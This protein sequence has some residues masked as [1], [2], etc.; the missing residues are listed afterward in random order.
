MCADYAHAKLKGK[1]SKQM[2]V[3]ARRTIFLYTYCCSV[4]QGGQAPAA[5]RPS[6]TGAVGSI[7]ISVIKKKLVTLFGEPRLGATP[8]ATTRYSMN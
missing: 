2:V 1:H 6:S 3:V 5:L 7:S 8:L 4:A